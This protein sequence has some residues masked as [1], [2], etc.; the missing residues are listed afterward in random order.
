MM[1]YSVDSFNAARSLANILLLI[2]KRPF[3]DEES[4]ISVRAATALA[5][6]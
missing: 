6:T 2:L 5:T 1:N 4:L 3:S